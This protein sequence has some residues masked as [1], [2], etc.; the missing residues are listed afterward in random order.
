M[1]DAK[2][3]FGMSTDRRRRRLHPS[4]TSP[5]APLSPFAFSKYFFSISFFF[6]LLPFRYLRFSLFLA[7]SAFADN[8]R[9][10]PSG[11]LSSPEDDSQVG[12]AREPT[13]ARA[14]QDTRRGN[15]ISRL[16][17]RSLAL[18]RSHTGRST[19]EGLPFHN[20]VDDA[21]LTRHDLS[22]MPDIDPHRYFVVSSFFFFNLTRN[23]PYIMDLRVIRIH[24]RFN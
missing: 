20:L 11:L 15:R 13:A 19:S 18:S 1:S 23:S 8:F 4:S 17:N 16:I 9:F 21:F 24:R 7:T 6:S 10:A 12:A 22:A 14:R 5:L 3:D 2:P